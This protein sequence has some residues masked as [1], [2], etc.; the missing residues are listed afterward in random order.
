MNRAS[1]CPYKQERRTPPELLYYIREEH[2]KFE[3]DLFASDEYHLCKKYFTK[4]N[5]A[6][7]HPWK[8]NII[9]ANPPF[10]LFDVVL[11]IAVHEKPN[12]K[13]LI[14][15][16]P[17]SILGNTYYNKFK[18]IIDVEILSGR[19]E[20]IPHPKSESKNHGVNGPS[21]LLI[22][23]RNTTGHIKIV[24]WK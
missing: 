1:K 16:A 20:Y 8:G 7:N 12:Y 11:P 21:C 17:S 19:V 18:Q 13:K 15:V 5:S 4:E 23:G 6:L 10:D 9:F 14:I 22:I 3:I 24:D 2:G